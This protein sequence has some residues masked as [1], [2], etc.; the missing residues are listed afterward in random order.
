[1]LTAAKAPC[2]ELQM[3]S[4]PVAVAPCARTSEPW[5]LVATILGSSI[6]FI[7]GTVV[8]VALPVL[9]SELGATVTQ[10]Q[11]VF[12]AYALVLA[13]LLLVGGSLGDRLGR[14]R[15]FVLGTVVFALASVACG[16]S[17]DIGALIGA[18]AL[19]GIG[20]AMLTPGSLAIISASF[21]EDRRGWAIGMWSS[22]TAITVAIAPP[23]GGWLIENASWRMIF[24]IN[25][26]IALVVIGIA[27]WHVPESRDESTMGHIDWLGAILATIGLGG[28]AFGLTESSSLGLTHP[29]V[30]LGLVIGAAALVALVFIERR[31][32]APMVPLDLFRSRSFSGA[33]ILTLLLY[34]G[35]SGTFFLL[36]F[37]LLQVQGY[38]T[39]EAGLA[40]LPF[41]L[42]LFVLSRWSGALV[43]RTGAR[44]LLIVGP[45]V[46][47]ASSILYALPGVGG[48]FWTTFFPA[49]LLHGIGMGITVAPLTTVVMKS[50]GE[51]RA[52]A[53]SGINNAVSRVAGLLAVAIV[54]V[55]AI[56]VFNRTLDTRLAGATV[57]PAAAQAIESQRTRLGAIE[58]P[59]GL[60][61]ATAAALRRAL[62]EAFLA[63]FRGAMLLSGGL[64]LAGGIAAAI[65][66]E[67]GVASRRTA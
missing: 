16:L 45:T 63:G 37:N 56:T 49:I 39:T 64:A 36:P 42:I 24:F 40:M 41:V 8:G 1:M 53:A 25:V 23:L 66:I 58:L 27:L 6:V 62:E 38:S 3:R 60:D 7:D 10:V 26:P 30:I 29:S 4:A 20:A 22:F 28:V 2:D 21:P 9:Q 50:V 47:A 17:P 5:I 14:R 57:P 33:N 51:S 35:L 13:S 43:D 11:W 34:A 12:E 61:P 46:V 59:E 18:R 15:I 19:Q 67:S 44:I 48:S 55:V 52:G 54:G 32:R 31:A 65:T